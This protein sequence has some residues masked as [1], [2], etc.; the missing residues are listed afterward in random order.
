MIRP[1]KLANI[2]RM[3]VLYV[4][5]VQVAA[6]FYNYF[7]IKYCQDYSGAFEL[8]ETALGRGTTV[9]ICSVGLVR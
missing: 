1:V 5:M 7:Q 3:R 2:I 8:L 4:K 9:V 6:L